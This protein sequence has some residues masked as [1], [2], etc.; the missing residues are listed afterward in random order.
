MV[1]DAGVERRGGDGVDDGGVVGL[2][3]VAL[4]VGIDE[5]GDQAAENGA[6]EP[7]CYHVEKVKVWKEKKKR[8]A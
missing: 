3:L 4:A 5:Q 2:L 6:A 7:H 8:R 1:G